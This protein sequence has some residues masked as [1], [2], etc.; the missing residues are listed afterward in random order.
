MKWLYKQKGQ[1]TIAIV[2]QQTNQVSVVQVPII[3]CTIL[4]LCLK[5]GAV[6]CQQ[7]WFLYLPCESATLMTIKKL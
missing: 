4:L 3:F 1:L 7:S 2:A 6:I 5:S